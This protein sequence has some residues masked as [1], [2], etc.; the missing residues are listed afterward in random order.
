MPVVTETFDAILFDMDGTLVDSTKGVIGAWNTFKETYPHLNVEEILS[1]AHGI[2]TVDNLR[3]HCGISDL[4]ELEEEAN[5]FEREIVNSSRKGGVEG[6]V[7]LPGVSGI[8][9]SLLGVED[10]HSRW[11]LCTSA[12]R[13]YATSALQIAGIPTPKKFIAAEDVQS[14][15][16]APDPYLK[17][18]EL[19]KAEPR[20]CLVV[21]DA[22]SGITS[23]HT[24]G[25]KTLAVITS[26]TREV[27][28]KAKPDFLVQNLSSV[29]MELTPNGV[30]VSMLIVE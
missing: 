16:P 27:M 14:G 5:R 21:E 6:I 30:V 19:C 13:A 4:E 26:H 1:T 22:P 25:C 20:R 15:K 11:A 8:C 23:G 28:V 7:P 10:A 29:S 9:E 24:A 2:R 18:A 3:V 17:G 12:T